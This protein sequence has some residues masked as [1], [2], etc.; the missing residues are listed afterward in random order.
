[1]LKRAIS[2]RR[3]GLVNDQGWNGSEFFNCYLRAC[4]MD[5]QLYSV[6]PLG[7]GRVEAFGITRGLGDP[8]FTE[9]DQSLLELFHEQL[10]A[11]G[12]APPKDPPQPP[13]TRRQRD[14]LRCLLAGAAEKAVAAELD[15][16][17]QTVHT[18]VKSVYAAYRVQSRAELLV[19]C[20]AGPPRC[21]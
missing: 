14:V 10:A 18:H 20:L 13:L 1:V 15:I 9:E 16:S 2:V 3:R 8:P 7:R 6:R 12:R 17:Q 19:K 5:D 4:G 11:F 21:D